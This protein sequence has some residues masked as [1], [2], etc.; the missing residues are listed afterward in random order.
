MSKDL[1]A[2]TGA[3]D[4]RQGIPAADPRPGDRIRCHR[5]AE[6][7]GRAAAHF[8]SE[9]ERRLARIEA[10]AGQVLQNDAPSQPGPPELRPVLDCATEARDLAQQFLRFS[11]ERLSSPDWIDL[12]DTLE[13]LRP[14]LHQLAGGSIRLTLDAGQ[15][16]LFVPAPAEAL[17]RVIVGLVTDAADALPVGGT[18]AVRGA[19]ASDAD[20]VVLT[21][22]PFGFGQQ[23]LPE[24]ATHDGLV[25][26]WGGTVRIACDHERHQVFYEMVLPAQAGAGG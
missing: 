16:R 15:G 6:T 1:G 2:S 8:V 23:P 19:L 24:P 4:R 20:E 18:L 11:G 13:S 9:L 17:A 3:H 14:L 25:T 12:A 26:S 22:T 7:V 10:L 5:G 21:V